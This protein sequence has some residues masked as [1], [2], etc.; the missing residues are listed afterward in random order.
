MER[1]T[2][3]STYSKNR[4]KKMKPKAQE[5]PSHGPGSHA[6]VYEGGSNEKD[7]ARSFKKRNA[8]PD[9]ADELPQHKYH[10]TP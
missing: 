4:K 7:K 8:R 1:S 10:R 5:T 3:S 9:R 2:P 6:K